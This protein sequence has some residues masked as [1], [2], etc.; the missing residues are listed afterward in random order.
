MGGEG[1]IAVAV[2]RHPTGGYD[3]FRVEIVGAAGF[4]QGEQMPV[5]P[6]HLDIGRFEGV[7]MGYRGAINGTD[8]SRPKAS[9][10]GD[11]PGPLI[12]PHI[13]AV[14]G[15]MAVGD[16]KALHHAIAVKPMVGW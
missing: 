6:E 10:G 9:A 11:F 12:G 16:V 3:S 1:E 8:K 4:L 5:V 15:Q 2:P 14:E 13:A 7:G